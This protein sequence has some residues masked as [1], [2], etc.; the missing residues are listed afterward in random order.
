MFYTT[1]RTENKIN[2]HF[3]YGKHATDDLGDGYLGSGVRLRDAIRKY[4]RAAFVKEIIG[5][6]RDEWEMNDAEYRLITPDLIADPRCYNLTAGGCG[7]AR[8]YRSAPKRRR[9]TDPDGF[10]L[11]GRLVD[12]AYHTRVPAKKLSDLVAGRRSV[13]RGYRA[14]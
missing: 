12:I 14:A 9:F 5:F 13:Y 2:G 3:Y 7:R 10:I 8:T 4:G 1:Y 11:E 6:H